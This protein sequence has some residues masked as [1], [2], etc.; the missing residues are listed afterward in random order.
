MS[1]LT[2]GLGSQ[3]KEKVFVLPDGTPDSDKLRMTKK[4]RLPFDRRSGKDRRKIWTE[5]H[6]PFQGVEMRTG[7]ERRSGKDRRKDW[8]GLPDFGSIIREEPQ[9]PE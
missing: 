6:F 3:T 4:H 5:E 1:L 2:E 7:K 9:I 8:I